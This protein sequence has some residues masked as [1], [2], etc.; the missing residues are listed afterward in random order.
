MAVENLK[1]LALTNAD[2][3]PVVIGNSRTLR[4]NLQQAVG[5]ALADA[6]ASIGST[7]RLVRIPSNATAVN[8]FLSNAA[9]TTT[10]AADIG[11]YN[12]KTGVVV[13]ADFFGSAVL[14]T[15]IQNELNVTRESTVYTLANL[16]KPIWQALGL[17]ED[18]QVEYDVTLTLTAANTTTAA[19]VALRVQYTQ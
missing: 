17:T 9:F 1:T 11:I 14:L 13:D 6:A 16:D 7:Y 10:G 12:A 18:P 15:S 2:A 4:A 3:K 5:N 19:Q 8:V